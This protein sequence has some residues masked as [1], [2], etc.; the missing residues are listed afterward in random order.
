M[1]KVCCNI[2]NKVY[3]SKYMSQHKKHCYILK[4]HMNTIMMLMKTLKKNLENILFK[5]I[6]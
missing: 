2:W 3:S 1:V 6:I 4:M 5:F